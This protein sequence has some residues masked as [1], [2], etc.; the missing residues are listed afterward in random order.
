MTPDVPLVRH[1]WPPTRARG[2]CTE[3]FHP[4]DNPVEWI[5]GSLNAQVAN[6]PTLAPAGRIRHV[7]GFFRQRSPAQLLATAAPHSSPWLPRW[8]RTEL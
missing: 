1:G 4:H 5:W 7:H 8:L 3:R 2:C 6:S